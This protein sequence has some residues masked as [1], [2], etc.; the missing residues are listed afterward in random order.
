[1][2][3]CLMTWHC[4]P[5]PHRPRQGSVQVVARQA[6]WGAQSELTTHSGRQLGADPKYP[7]AQEQRHVSPSTL[8]VLYGPQKL[9][10]HGSLSSG[11]SCGSTSNHAIIISVRTWC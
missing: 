6:S 7:G 1:M 8:W 9:L 10:P 11:G 4:A 3:W 2:G 5:S